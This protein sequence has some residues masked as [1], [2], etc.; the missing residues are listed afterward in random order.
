MDF[1]KSSEFKYII[2][3]IIISAIISLFFICVILS[4]DGALTFITQSS[5][6]LTGFKAHTGDIHYNGSRLFYVK[7][8]L[9]FLFANKINHPDFIGVNFLSYLVGGILGLGILLKLVSVIKN[10]K[11][12]KKSKIIL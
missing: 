9:T 1:F 7:N 11:P 10:I 2:I 8:F 12:L 6:S 4:F 3:S 5:D